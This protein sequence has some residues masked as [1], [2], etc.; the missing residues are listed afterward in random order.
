MNDVGNFPSGRLL[1]YN[2]CG[3]YPLCMP[4]FS[5]YPTLAVK[6]ICQVR[7]S[8]LSHLNDVVNAH[9]YELQIRLK[10]ILI[11][12]GIRDCKLETYCWPQAV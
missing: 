1:K 5:H 12:S 10:H 7:A 8:F 4:L 3:A 6:I 2:Y 11:Q 9:Y